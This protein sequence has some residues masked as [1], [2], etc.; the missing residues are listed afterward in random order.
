MAVMAPFGWNEYISLSLVQLA[1]HDPPLLSRVDP[2]VKNSTSKSPQAA[3]LR[4]PGLLPGL[5]ASALPISHR[6]VRPASSANATVFD[7]PSEQS[8]SRTVTDSP[9]AVR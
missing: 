4:R 3:S 2:W 5:P 7:S 8:L 9:L 1:K 6:V